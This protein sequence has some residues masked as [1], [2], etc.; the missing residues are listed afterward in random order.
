MV[1]ASAVLLLGLALFFMRDVRGLG[2]SRVAAQGFN[3]IKDGDNQAGLGKYEQ[4][5]KLNPEVEL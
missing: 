2:A 4:A 1:I 3:L 5:V